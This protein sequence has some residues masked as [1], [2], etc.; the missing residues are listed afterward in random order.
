M[1]KQFFIHIDADAFF[2]SVEQ[3]IHRELRG[4][5]VVTGRDGS[6]AVSLSY[7]AKALGV[8][9]TMPI[10]EIRVNHPEVAIVVSD[11]FMY[12]LYSDKM[13]AI[14]YEHIPEIRRQSVDECSADLSHRFTSFEDLACAAREI[15]KEL[16]T[17]LACSFSIGISSSPMLAKMAS[18][19][20][21]PSGLTVIDPLSDTN[22]HH[23]AIHKVPGF[24]ERVCAQFEKFNIK[25]IG[26]FI[27]NYPN[28]RQH[29]SVVSDDIFQQLQGFP[30]LRS[31][32]SKP[33]ESMNRARSFK[34]TSCRDEVFGQLILN[35]EH[36]MRRM[37][38][39][40]VSCRQLRLELRSAERKSF[41][42]SIR[43]PIASRDH[44]L[45]MEHVHLLFEKAWDSQERYRYVSLTMSGLEPSSTHQMNLF[46][47]PR[48]APRYENISKA[49]DALDARYGKTVMSVASTLVLPRDLGSHV[50]PSKQALTLK[51]P[52]LPGEEMFKR[53]RYP[54]LG[55]IN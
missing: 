2:A 38:E 27:L 19:M 15:Q 31:W 9:R 48:E 49:L 32:V 6:I 3:S 24:G 30:S 20:N 21:K 47:E 54:F 11:Y 22:Y 14:I 28:I 50:N 33:Q 35:Y 17:K 5:P 46:E 18:G 1:A 16:E 34:V 43:L 53:L 8:H 40:D 51:Y 37:R 12:S 10:H 45:L 36:L 44:E 7:E 39:M 23:M 42:Q 55:N 52:L 4:R 26:D 13:L 41:S 29:F 25:N